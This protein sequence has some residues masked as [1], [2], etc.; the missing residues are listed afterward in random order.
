MGP[1]V[2]EFKVGELPCAVVSDG[3]AAAP[4]TLFFNPESG[5]SDAAL[6]QGLLVERNVRTT[7]D[8]NYNSLLVHARSGVVLID[9]GLGER[10]IGYGEDLGAL[11][12]KLGANLAA[13]AV[14]PGSVRTVVFTHLH[15]DHV[16][17]AIWSGVRTFARAEHVASAAEV[18]FWT[19]AEARTGRAASEADQAGA[20]LAALGPHLRAIGFDVAITP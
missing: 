1:R 8:V 2:Y 17:G 11:L 13:A 18:A 6:R 12:G 14:S 3:A 15:Q 7:I 4:L 19:S 10:F 16:R 20:A 9:T 5:V